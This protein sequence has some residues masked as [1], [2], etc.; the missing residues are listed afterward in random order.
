L[1]VG[2]LAP[3]P[4]LRADPARLTQ[5]LRNLLDNAVIH[6]PRGGTVRVSASVGPAGVGIVVSDSGPGIPAEHLDQ[7]FDR[8][9]RTDPSR[10]RATGGAGLGLAI[11]RQIVELH[12]GRVRVASPPGSGAAFTVDWPVFIESSQSVRLIDA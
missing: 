11:V 3:L 4:P 10:T 12:G 8:F 7:V 6:T 1:Q 5:V 9:Y 2:E